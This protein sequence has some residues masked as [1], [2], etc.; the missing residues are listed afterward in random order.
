MKYIY[1]YFAKIHTSPVETVHFDGITVCNDPIGS[2][3]LYTETKKKIAEAEEPHYDYSKLI[4][5]S[6]SL[7]HTI[8]EEDDEI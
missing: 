2:Y 8:T 3:T 5:C 4:I 6:L 1:H 7:L